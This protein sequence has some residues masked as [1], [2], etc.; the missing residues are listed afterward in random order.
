MSTWG[1]GGW[2]VWRAGGITQGQEETLGSD[3]DVRYFYGSNGFADVTYVKHTKLYTFNMSNLLYI[4]YI[5]I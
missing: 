1:L 2:M 4:N 5:S 3:E